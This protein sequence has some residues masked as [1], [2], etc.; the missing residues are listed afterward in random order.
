MGHGPVFRLAAT[1]EDDILFTELNEFGRVSYAVGAGGA[2]RGD[3][4]VHAFDLEGRCEAGRD[5]AA[6]RAGDAVG[7]DA[8]QAF[9][10]HDVGGLEL[11]L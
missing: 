5:G 9:L 1:G 3:R 11:L 2:G 6:H 4:V 10:A 7:S 8:A